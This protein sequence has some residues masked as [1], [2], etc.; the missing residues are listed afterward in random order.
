MAEILQKMRVMMILQARK[1]IKQGE[2]TYAS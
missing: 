2:V 1:T